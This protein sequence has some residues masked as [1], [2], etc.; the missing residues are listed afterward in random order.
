MTHIQYRHTYSTIAYIVGTSAPGAV[1]IVVI[2]MVIVVL[3][4]AVPVVLRAQVR[5][6]PV[7]VSVLRC[8]V[9]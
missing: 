6:R 1:V 9:R 2:I 4:L 7:Q 3:V 8:V 5:Q